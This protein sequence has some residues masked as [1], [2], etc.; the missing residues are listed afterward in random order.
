MLSLPVRQIR[1]SALLLSGRLL[2][3]GLN[4]LSQLI[5]VRYLSTQHYGALAYALSIVAFCQ[6]FSSLGLKSTVSRFVP[7]FHEENDRQRIAGTLMVVLVTILLTGSLAVVL[8]NLWPELFSGVLSADAGSRALVAVLIFLV[9]VEAFDLAVINLF[10]SFGRSKSIFLRK[11]LLSP[12][13]KLAVVATLVL[14]GSGPLAVAY[15]LLLA[16]VLGGA[17]STYLLRTLLSEEGLFRR[18]RFD[19]IQYP[20]K[21]LFS[22]AIP[23]LTSDLVPVAMHSFNLMLL[24]Y[25][26][27]PE[28]VAAYAVVLPAAR[29]NRIVLSSMTVLYT[30]N[31]AR[32][33]ARRDKAGVQSLYWETAVWLVCFSF[34]LFAMTISMSRPLTEFLYGSRYAE[35]SLILML[36]SIG[37]FFNVALGCNGHTL[38]VLGKIRALVTID[39]ISLTFCLAASLMLAPRLGALGSAIATCCTMVLQNLLRQSALKFSAGLSFLERRN[40]VLLLTT[41]AGLLILQRLQATGD[42]HIFGAS[43][44]VGAATGILLLVVRKRLDIEN[45]FP[46]LL[47]VPLVRSLLA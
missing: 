16:G 42:L 32:L 7:I 25:L 36:L 43:A 11:H 26:H 19:E 45:H 47:R 2:S 46:E 35:S 5:L 37:Y 12:S 31:A 44:I 39:G 17:V 38:K 1:G 21:Q 14:S 6:A 20:V 18:L 15:G 41:T 8:I 34:P 9:P 40:L 22:F 10:A 29:L 28:S 4:F 27:G 3:V 13:L 33:H 30:P 24:G 23:T